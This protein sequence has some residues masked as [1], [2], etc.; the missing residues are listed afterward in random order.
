MR[1]PSRCTPMRSACTLHGARGPF[2]PALSPS[3]IV[4][5]PATMSD[6]LKAGPN[7]PRAPW[8]VQALRI[9]VHRDGSRIGVMAYSEEHAR[10]WATPLV[11]LEF[12]ERLLANYATD[13]EDRKLLKNVDIFVLP[14]ANVDGANYS[15]NDYNFQ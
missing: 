2:G 7:G 6:G 15:F 12:A 11:T 3:L 9:G 13:S 14:V 4:A 5:G 1:E 8:S 10:E